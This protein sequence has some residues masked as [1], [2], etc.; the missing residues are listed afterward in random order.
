VAVV[1]LGTRAVGAAGSVVAGVVATSG[2]V[3][4]SALEF[5]NQRSGKAKRQALRTWV[6]VAE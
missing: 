1:T 4:E 2:S 5:G 3:R 6:L